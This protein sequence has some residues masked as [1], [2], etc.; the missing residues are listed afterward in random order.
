MDIKL[1]N[2]FSLVELMVALSLASVIL[3]FG[4]PGFQS[5]VRDNRLAAESSR[6][7]TALN[8]ARSEAIKRGQQVTLCKADPNAAPPACNIAACN[9][10]TGANCWEQGWLVFADANGNGILND[11]TDIASCPSGDCTIR[12]F[13][14]LPHGLTLRTSNISR[15]VA[16]QSPGTART[17]NGLVSDSFR[18]CQG[19]DTTH[20]RSVVLNAI[21]RPRVDQGTK[22]CP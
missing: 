15:W 10:A 11:G 9:T 7:V 21:G 14:A 16:Y 22:T 1:T 18:L 5:M 19:A 13:E 17:S 3:A 20:A 4:V 2:G 12:I 8:L 6:L